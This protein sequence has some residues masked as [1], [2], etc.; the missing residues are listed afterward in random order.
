MKLVL[1]QEQDYLWQQVDLLC[2]WQFAEIQNKFSG[3]EIVSA[4][5]SS[6]EIF[7]TWI[8]RQTWL[9]RLS[10]LVWRCAAHKQWLKHSQ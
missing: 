8:G 5:V 4:I 2:S 9:P 10:M 1:H 3:L 6:D 7:W